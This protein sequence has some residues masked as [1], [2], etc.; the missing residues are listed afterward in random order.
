MLAKC[1]FLIHSNH[2]QQ[3]TLK[4]IF[5]SCSCPWSA[6][7][8]RR[9]AT[10]PWLSNT[11]ELAL[12]V[13]VWENQ[14]RGHESQRTDPASCLFPHDWKEW[15]SQGNV[16]E[17]TFVVR[18]GRT[19]RL[20]NSANIQAQNQVICWSTPM[21]TLPVICWSVG[22]GTGVVSVIW[23]QDCRI[24]KTQGS[25]AMSRKSPSDGPASLVQ[26]RTGVLIQTNDS[27]Q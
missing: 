22:S 26:Q 15:T 11:V 6:A 12:K 16:G 13:Y 1:K 25:K 9:V 5:L 23:T 3:F 20:I 14:L 7:A 27:L 2:N 21:F 19:D 17:L 8:L 18:M 4:S 24:A 10:T